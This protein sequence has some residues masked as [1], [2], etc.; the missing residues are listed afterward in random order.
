MAKFLSGTSPAGFE[1]P[2]LRAVGFRSA[3]LWSRHRPTKL[4]RVRKRLLRERRNFADLQCSTGTNIMPFSPGAWTPDL[5]PPFWRWS[6]N[7]KRD[8]GLV[9][10]MSQG[11]VSPK[12]LPDSSF[13]YFPLPL[14][15]PGPENSI[16]ACLTKSWTS[17][18]DEKQPVLI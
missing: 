15:L 10:S 7:C 18:G 14:R 8:P 13:Y 4:G 16:I 3:D 12:E 6:A 5:F 9:A 11:F 17:E 1:K 2:V